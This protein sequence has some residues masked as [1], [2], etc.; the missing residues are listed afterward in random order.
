MQPAAVKFGLVTILVHWVTALG[1]VV[2]AAIGLVSV[3]T[4][5]TDLTRLATAVHQS[6]GTALFAVVVFRTLWRLT[7][8]APPPIAGTP[9]MQRLAANA[10]HALL[11]VSLFALPITGY[12][13]LAARGRDITIFGLFDL[14]HI[15]PL[16]RPLSV[17]AQN[18]HMY[19]QYFLYAL[20]L[21]HVGAALYHHYVMKDGLLRRMW[22]WPA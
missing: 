2:A 15:V 1:V 16:S 19:L 7:H 18:M 17:N 12:I 3:Y 11:Y 10:T 5:S 20:V 13:G 8:P 6:I 4:N 22:G 9:R 14:P 21:L